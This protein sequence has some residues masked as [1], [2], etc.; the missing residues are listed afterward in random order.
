MGSVL[1]EAEVVVCVAETLWAHYGYVKDYGPWVDAKT[2]PGGAGVAAGACERAAQAVVTRLAPY[3]QASVPEEVSAVPDLY[4][5]IHLWA[6]GSGRTRRQGGELV[7]GPAGA[8][9]VLHYHGAVERYEGAGVPLG[10]GTSNHAELMAIKLGLETI[11]DAERVRPVVL[12]SDSQYALGAVR[13]SN[14][15]IANADL[16]GELRRLARGF[17]QLSFVHVRGHTGVMF[18]EVA[19]D[20]AGRAARSQRPVPLADVWSPPSPSSSNLPPRP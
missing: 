19:D 18:N 14:R 15:A 2:R 3:L 12:H 16:I 10:T 9:Y 20:L 8:G 1:F 6:D 17:P 13:G 5:P 4:S 7:N 11:P